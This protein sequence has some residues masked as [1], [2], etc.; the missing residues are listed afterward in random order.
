MFT[1]RTATLG[2]FAGRFDLEVVRDCAFSYAAK[3]PSRLDGRLVA[4]GSPQ[5]IAEA[6]AE[7]GIVGIVTTPA[8][9]EAV[10]AAIGAAYCPKP[11]SAL[12][13]IHDDIARRPDFQ[14][15]SFPT[16][17]HPTAVIHPSAVVASQDVVIGEG[18]IIAENA[19]ICPRSI[20]GRF[21]T[22]GPGTVVG[23]D[24]F[25][26]NTTVRPHRI[27]F[28]AG[29]V[30]IGDHVE[31]QAKCTIVRS[32]FGGFTLIGDES[33]FDCQIHLAHD[34]AVGRRV[35]V[36]ACAEI[37]GR[38]TIGDDV[39]VGPNVSIS[40]G[41]SIAEGATVTIGAVVVRDV[42][43]GTRVTGNFALLHHKWI[44]FIRSIR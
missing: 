33:K 29:G 21:S 28:Q 43:A 34:C 22:I 12:F 41:I 39:F 14:W 38:V 2:E 26:V 36:A 23:C 11:L 8:L 17:I 30:R 31:I 19:V 10:P 13:A 9:A 18:C 6:V 37:S 24:A 4:C 1:N 27:L 32:T 15:T 7:D 5:H 42:A 35:R 40:N 44:D 16:S 3:I 25:E 20:I